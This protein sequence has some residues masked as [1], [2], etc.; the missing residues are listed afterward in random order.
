VLCSVV[1]EVV[2]FE[3]RTVVSSVVV[4]EVDVRGAS[5][6]QPNSAP[7]TEATRQGSKNVFIIWIS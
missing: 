4:E 5:E 3:G 7:R 1:V 6:A 2:G